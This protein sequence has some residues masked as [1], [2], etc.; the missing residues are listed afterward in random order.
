ML[1]F[2]PGPSKLYTGIDLHIQEAIA[3]G[4]LSMNHRSIDFMTLYQ[5]VQERL[6][7]Y[8]DLPKGYNVYFTSSA[9]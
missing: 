2:Y 5:Q 4:I 9:T 7:T 8:Y 1:N 3:S 6:E